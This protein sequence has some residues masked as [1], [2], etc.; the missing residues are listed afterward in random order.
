MPVRIERVTF[1]NFRAYRGRV[2]I[3][4]PPSADPARTVYLVGGENGAGKTSLL[5]ALGFALYGIEADGISYRSGRREAAAAYRAALEECYNRHANVDGDTVMS[6]AVEVEANGVHY[7]IHREWWF[8]EGHLTD[9]EVRIRI[10]GLPVERADGEATE[11]DDRADAVAQLTE[12]VLPAR[13]ARF[14][15]FDGEEV[16]SIAKRDLGKSVISGLDDLLGLDSIAKLGKELSNIERRERDRIK[17]DEDAA[18]YDECR[19]RNNDAET[20]AIE[21]DR[22]LE[23]ALMEMEAVEERLDTTNEELGRIFDGYAVQGVEDLKAQRA[24]LIGEMEELSREFARSL[25]DS[26]ATIASQDL[27]LALRPEVSIAL[28]T[29]KQLQLHEAADERVNA[30]IN[31]VLRREVKPALTAMQKEQL[32]DH[33]GDA[34]D[35]VRRETASGDSPLAALSDT[36]LQ[37]LNGRLAGDLNDAFGSVREQARRRLELKRRIRLVESHLRKFEKSSEAAA[38]IER[39]DQ[40][41]KMIGEKQVDLDALKVAAKEAEDLAKETAEA[42]MAAEEA[43]ASSKLGAA[44]VVVARKA[45]RA[46][47]R[48][49]S[50]IRQQRACELEGDVSKTLQQLLHR[51]GALDRVKIDA[52]SSAVALLDGQ[53]EE[54]PVP[55]AGEKEIFALSLIHGLGKLSHREAPL[56]IDTPL[57]RLDKA[58]RHAI[59]A[60]F[61]PSASHQVIVLSTD[62]EIDEELYEVIRPHLAWQATIRAS[63]DGAYVDTSAYFEQ[64][65]L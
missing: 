50:E 29:R 8:E 25:T 61:M 38:C 39:R 23:S 9:E 30:I 47:A 22:A 64:G 46:L 53:G 65:P 55:S 63:D 2:E 44:K 12:T 42:V 34:A 15:F 32:L 14:F 51:A 1:Q 7:D 35:K 27:L 11:F 19:R 5:M 24:R 13:A 10:E 56:V 45:R 26:V 52:T 48:F 41:V 62:S 59:V 21:A 20:R 43:M 49:A 33:V 16:A 58:H 6:V 40:L 4:F 37:R 60:D 28:E 54:I 17:Q 36:D 31:E 57:G 3:A 18:E